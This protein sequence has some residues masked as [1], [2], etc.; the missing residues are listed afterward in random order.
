M[1][2]SPLDK[3]YQWEAA[4]PNKIFLRQPIDGKWHEYSFAK[5]G[6]EIR[7]MATGLRQM[8]FP[9][10]STIAILSKNCAHWIMA[11]LAIWMAGYISVPIY[12]SLS[13][14]A[15]KYVLDH[16]EAKAIF[17]GKLD[18]Y[19]NQKPAIPESVIK[20]TFPFYG[21]KE[22]LRWNDFLKKNS[23]QSFH[24]TADSLA[25]I[26]YSSGTTG[27]P[28]GVMLT[29]GALD[30]LG[31]SAV[32]SFGIDKAH[33]F[34]SYLPLAHIAE[35]AYIEMV[36]LYSG[37]AIAFSESL[38][39]F[40]QNLGEVQPVIFGGVPRIYAKFQEGIL[41]KLSQKKLDRLLSIPIVKSL[42]RKLIQ[43][44]LG[45]SKAKIVGCGAAPIPVSLLEWYKNLGIKIQEL[46]GM[47]ENCGYCTGDHGSDFKFGTV[48]RAWKEVELKLS[49]EGEILM[50]SNALMKGYFKDP[51]ATNS[52]FTSDG[53]FKTGD[54]G[55]IDKEGFLT[56]VGRLKDQF[57]TDKGKFVAPA[58]I[59]MKLLGNTD[60]EQVSVVG[61]GV[62]QPI[63][64]INLSVTG[65]K[66]TQSEII[67][68]ITVTLS[69][70][71]P[72]LETFERLAKAVIMKKDWSIANGLLTPT[73]KVKR[74]EVEKIHLKMYPTW[75]KSKSVVVW[76]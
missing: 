49:G 64:L 33:N 72:T 69:Q 47:T 16:S 66:K 44:K 67:E 8:N 27:T 45:L 55:T 76:E 59:E 32:V 9:A 73:L 4:T 41:S 7:S 56:L 30:F 75:Y 10:G 39:K 46:Y 54:S 60:I 29:F 51:E 38:E 63:A 1:N 70:L 37:S 11:D 65:K 20:I 12:P 15:V 24:P 40:P 14:A 6:E 58:S 71:N 50:K 48:G 68:S 18:D 36:A 3:F 13:A 57:K 28:K 34:F 61:N 21:P 35:R 42:I 25:T 2:S 52:V 62:P 31:K 19:G 5:A 74:N 17:V 53:F 22:A 26:I 43:K 23:I